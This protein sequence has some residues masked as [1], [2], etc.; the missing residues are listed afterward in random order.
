MRT[1]ALVGAMI[2]AA[3]AVLWALIAP[4]AKLHDAQLNDPAGAGRAP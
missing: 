3:A 4:I 2:L 1:K